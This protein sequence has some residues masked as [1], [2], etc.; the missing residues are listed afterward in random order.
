MDIKSQLYS[1]YLDLLNKISDFSSGKIKNYPSLSYKNL[2]VSQLISNIKD[3][4]SELINLK[5]SQ[6]ISQN[7][8]TN[9]YLLLENYTK[10]LEY[11][12]KKFYHEIF[13]YKIQN[14]ALEDK[15]KMY[16]MIQI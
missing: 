16:K 3:S 11:D 1:Y 2:E 10:K 14:N 12:L 5:V 9:N 4:P 13:E 8:N 6:V 7:I 15:I